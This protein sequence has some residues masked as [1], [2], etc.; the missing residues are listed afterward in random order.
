MASLEFLISGKVQGVYFR[1]HTKQEADKLGLS[2]WVRNTE[3]GKVTGCAYGDREV[4]K[5]LAIW[6]RKGPS[7]ARVKKLEINWGKAK[8]QAEDFEIIK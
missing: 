1:L 6:L 7:S 2:G 3:D 4:L 5:K 8:T